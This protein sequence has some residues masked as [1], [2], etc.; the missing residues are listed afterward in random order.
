MMMKMIGLVCLGALF[1]IGCS[2]PTASTTNVADN[3]QT[4]PSDD[5][6]TQSNADVVE[7][8]HLSLDL[9]IDFDQ[10]QIR[11]IAGW[12]IANPKGED[13]LRLDTHDLTIDSVFVNG[14]K[15]A[16]RIGQP[17]PHLGSVLA[18]P[19][20]KNTSRVDIY[21]ATGASPRA[22]QWMDPQQ[23]LGKK[24]PF[25]YTQSESIYAR[26]WIPTP[27]GPGIRFSYDARVQ[28]PE[29]LM[30]LMSATNPVEM[31]DSGIYHFNMEIPIPAYLLALAVGDVRFRAIDDRVGVY[32]EPEMI[33]RAFREFSEVGDMVKQ[34]EALYG[35]YRW[36]RYDMIVLPSGFPLGGME[37]P[38]LT[39]ATPTIISGDQSLVNLIAHELAHSWSGNLVTNH[40]WNDFWLNEGFT[41]YFERRLTEAMNDK[42]YAEMLWELGYQDLVREI[43]HLDSQD[44]RLKINLTGRDPDEGLTDVAYEKGAL[45]LR[46]IEESVG[47]ERFDTFLRSYFDQ[48][49]FKTMTTERFLDFLHDNLIK[50]DK[51]L[52]ENLN[53]PAWVYGPGIP[54]NAPRADMARFNLVNEQRNHF[55]NGTKA[56]ALKTDNWT[57]Y[58]WLHFLRKMP[59]PLDKDQMQ[60]LDKAFRFTSSGNSEIANLWYI[61]AVAADYETAYPAIDRFL[62][63]VGRRKFLT[64]LYGEMMQTGKENMAK[65]FYRK[66]RGNYH[67]LAQMTLDELVGR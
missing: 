60:E 28:V 20:Q 65:G 26:S 9:K 23:T 52:E 66:Y 46:L 40:T 18:I 5:L 44:T 53:I 64:P 39:F 57:T 61:M 56:S 14:S 62:S 43:G 41:V 63:T 21:Y 37:N 54:E 10:K 13:T 38:R 34:A 50:G 19:I 2:A 36:G 32:A 45:F 1:Q 67:P 49:A 17:I 31:N 24:K 35:P 51:A 6:H 58:E 48:H 22:L 47:R 29:G 59:K 7:T 25:L 11:G 4:F 55:L 42:S 30:A 16:F 27:D 8:K 33:E 15:S 12:Q 3:E